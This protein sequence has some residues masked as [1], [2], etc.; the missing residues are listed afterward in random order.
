MFRRF[1][2]GIS[3]QG[4]PIDITTPPD[5]DAVIDES[6][7]L[8]SESK[9]SD[10]SD[11]APS[12][13]SPLKASVWLDTTSWDEDDEDS[14]PECTFDRRKNKITTRFFQLEYNEG[15]VFYIFYLLVFLAFTRG[16]L[17]MYYFFTLP[18]SKLLS[19]YLAVFLLYVAI[20]S[21]WHYHIRYTKF[22][23]FE[24]ELDAPF[25]R[26]AFLTE[27]CAWMGLGFLANIK[28]QCEKAGI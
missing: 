11:L 15:R 6:M 23:L 18:N 7:D 9:D 25:V 24:E 3:G 14:N 8:K 4:R 20:S 13:R 17:A 28:A 27:F 26:F 1:R 5:T 22:Y 19:R 10:S 2:K 16:I 12:S 21:G